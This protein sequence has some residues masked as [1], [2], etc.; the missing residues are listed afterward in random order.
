M[1]L[2]L[3][4]AESTNSIAWNYTKVAIQEQ[5]QRRGGGS[6]TY[7]S[8]S[9]GSLGAA[10]V[11]EIP[12]ILPLQAVH[13]LLANLMLTFSLRS[14]VVIMCV[15]IDGGECSFVFV[16]LSWT[17]WLNHDDDDWRP[18]LK[19][20]RMIWGDDKDEDWKALLLPK[21]AGKRSLLFAWKWISNT[22]RYS[23]LIRFSLFFFFGSLICFSF[24]FLRLF[25]WVVV[26]PPSK[27]RDR[28]FSFWFVC[29]L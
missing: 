4:K 11:K 26:V 7:R 19:H 17:S 15:V 10:F 9:G 28:R 5:N 18:R 3:A 2:E 23:S 16:F 24:L 1:E 27:I 13:L 14:R 29:W 21:L 22:R 8:S 6:L 12:N 25:T 20:E